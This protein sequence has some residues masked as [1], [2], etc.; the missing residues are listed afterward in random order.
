EERQVEFGLGGG[1]ELDLRLLGGLFEPLQ[2]KLI[3]AQIDALFLLELVGEIIDEAHIEVFAA[4]ERIA[5][6]GFHLEHTVADL[7]NGNIE[8]ASAKVVD[9]DRARLL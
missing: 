3:A 6:R 7:K 1:R 2:R 8:G 4:Q 9:R 5:V